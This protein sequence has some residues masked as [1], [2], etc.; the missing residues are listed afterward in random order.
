MEEADDLRTWGVLAREFDTAMNLGWIGLKLNFFAPHENQPERYSPLMKRTFRKHI[1]RV[2]GTLM[3]FPSN[4]NLWDLWAW[5]S[6][7]LN[8]RPVFKFIHGLDPF[9]PCPTPKVAAWLT[10]LA[11]SKEDWEN[12]AHFAKLGRDF[13]SIKFESRTTWSPGWVSTNTVSQPLP[14]F[15][16]ES[17]YYPLLEAL[18]K[19]GRTEDANDVF[20]ELIRT[21]GK[22]RARDFERIAKIARPDFY[23]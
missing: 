13:D 12:I 17:S 1:G 2:E 16:E 15:P 21:A 10:A 19:L 14:G 9:N 22:H 8:D 6:R 5:M 11:K 4:D 23:S 3:E 18:L 7:T 20:D